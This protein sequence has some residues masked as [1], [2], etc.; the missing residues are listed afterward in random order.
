M[1]SSP[2]LSRRR[3]GAEFRQL[4]EEAGVSSADA[5]EALDCSISKISRIETGATAPRRPEIDALLRLYGRSEPALRDELVKLAAD[6]RQAAWYDQFGDLVEA[7]SMLHRLIGL[8]AGASQIRAYACG[9]LPGLLQTEGYARAV[10]AVARPAASAAEIDRLVDFR[11]AR[12]GVLARRERAPRLRALL[13]E[14][15]LRRPAQGD[16]VM[17]KQIE[18]LAD[19]AESGA[20]P[21]EIRVLP[22]VAGLHGL[23][24]GELYL[25]SFDGEQDD[26]IFLE[27]QEGAVLQEKS[28]VVHALGERFDVAWKAGLEGGELLALLKEV[29]EDSP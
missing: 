13:D 5:A 7:G 28:E 11:M 27:G 4:R 26:A 8:E 25:M 12:K 9:W 20:G 29:A 14:S 22:F 15:V 19:L 3:L 2:V 18:H 17:R 1:T 16:G 23:L 10:L 24:G 21:V 6:G